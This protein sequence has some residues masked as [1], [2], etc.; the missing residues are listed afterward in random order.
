[1]VSKVLLELFDRIFNERS[2]K[3]KKTL[4]K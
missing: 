1:V 3:N 4:S 2:L